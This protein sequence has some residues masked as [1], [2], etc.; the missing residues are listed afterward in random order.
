MIDSG[1]VLE[2]NAT[3]TQT[4]KFTGTGGE[5]TLDLSTFGGTIQ[6]LVATDKLD[7]QTIGY[8][9][10]T[11]ATYDRVTGDLFVTVRQWS[12]HHAQAGHHDR[13]HQRRICRHG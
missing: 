3:D 1:T 12:Q 9:D 2:L 7:L 6:G 13:L 11:T 10:S 8:G 4:V 5:L